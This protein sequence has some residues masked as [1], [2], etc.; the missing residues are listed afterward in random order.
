M[1]VTRQGAGV[2]ELPGADATLRV[3]PAIVASV[4]RPG[5]VSAAISLRDLGGGAGR[6]SVSL[7]TGGVER[8]VDSRVTV[9]RG[10][11]TALALRL[12]RGGNGELVVRDTSGTEVARAPVVPARPAATP[13]GA[14]GTPEVTVG[15][16]FAEVRVRLGALRRASARVVNV[17]L[18]GV[19]MELV[20]TGG[21][22]PL[23]V[24]GAKQS[25]R[26]GG[27]HVPLP[28]GA[29]AGLR[30]RGPRRRLP[31]AGARAGPGRSAPHEHERALHTSLR[32]ERSAA[33]TLR[34]PLRRS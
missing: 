18:H 17:A 1:P 11:D 23:A 5:A 26:V 28:G 8:V 22:E 20:P 27:R 2:A 14:L 13:A 12:P 29:P 34:L 21:G 33:V 10:R 24:A 19:A 15:T 16:R 7:R 32:P 4:T 9:R 30:P 3:E 6:Y 25:G 31:P